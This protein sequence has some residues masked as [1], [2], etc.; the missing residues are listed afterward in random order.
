MSKL[1][2]RMELYNLSKVK[3][4]SEVNLHEK[5]NMNELSLYWDRKESVTLRC[6]K[7]RNEEEVLES[8]LP[9]K[10]LKILEID[11]YVGCNIPQWMRDPHMFQYLRETAQDAKIYR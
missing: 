10:M 11:G 7:V 6:G 1:G 4:G 9:H 8:V 2:N 3:R 5:H